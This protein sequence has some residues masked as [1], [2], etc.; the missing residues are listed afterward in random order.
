MLAEGH[1]DRLGSQ[2]ALEG[3]GSMTSFSDSTPPTALPLCSVWRACDTFKL[4]WIIGGGHALHAGSDGGYATRSNS[5]G[6]HALCAVGGGSRG[7]CALP[8]GSARG[9]GPWAA[10]YAGGRERRAR[11]DALYAA[12][13][14]GGRRGVRYVLELLE[15]VDSV[16]CLLCSVYWSSWR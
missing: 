10:L 16:F 1:P 9:D 4:W 3:R 6:W 12:L 15:A 14:V 7:G 5:G 13:H 2:H 11:G 8:A